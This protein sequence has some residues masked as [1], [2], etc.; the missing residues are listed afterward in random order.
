MNPICV[1]VTTAPVTREGVVDFLWPLQRSELIAV[2]DYFLVSASAYLRSVMVEDKGADVFGKVLLAAYLGELLTLYKAQALI[3][4]FRSL[5]R[6]PQFPDNSRIMAPLACGEPLAA[7]GAVSM[8]QEGAARP[9]TLHR[10]ARNVKNFLMPD[11]IVRRPMAAVDV[12][13]DIVTVAFGEMIL[14][15]AVAI[16]DKV[17][18]VRFDEWFYPLGANDGRNHGSAPKP[19]LVSALADISAAAYRVGGEPFEAPVARHLRGWIERAGLLA[20]RYIGRVLS[21]TRKVP[22][23]L[24]RGT[25]GHLYGR[26]LS[27]ACHEV[28]GTVT[29]H[30]HAHG[31]GMFASFSDTV[32][33]YPGCDRFMVWTKMQQRMSLASLRHD[34]ILQDAAPVIEVVPGTFRPKIQSARAAQTKRNKPVRRIMYVG[35]D[36]GDESGPL[37]PLIPGLVLLDWEVRLVSRLIDWGYEVMIK[38]HPEV[39]LKTAHVFSRFGATVVGGR[40]EDVYAESDLVIFGQPNA[41][42]FFGILGTDHPI[43]VADTAVHVWQPEALEMLKRRCGFA[44]CVYGPDNRLEMNW[45]EVRVAIEIAPMLSDDTLYKSYLDTGAMAA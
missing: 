40:F 20:D 15:H 37:T 17:R 7:P 11:V 44:R 41:T 31:Q 1:D 34:L 29:G 2:R 43:V 16:Q 42:S 36:Y 8:L 4:R 30:D 24:W 26:L 5:G 6:E 39:K 13:S 12:D 9:S 19:A 25:G 21:Q 28:G 38:P 10:L 23:R 14:Q 32:L 45:D 35:T 33:E 18:F 3:R 22:R 27:Y